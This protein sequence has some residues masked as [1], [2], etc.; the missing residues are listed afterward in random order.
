[1]AGGEGS[2][3][4]PLTCDCPKPMLRLMGRPLMEY[5]VQLLHRHGIHQIAATLGYLPDPILDYFAESGLHFRIEKTPM[6]TA[7]SVKQAAEFL[8]ER[9]IVLSGDG[10]TDIDLGAALRFHMEKRALATL[11]LKKHPQPQEYGM[12]VTDAYGRI[13]SFHEKP[14]RSDAYSSLINTGIYILERAVLDLIPPNRPYDFGHDLFPAM[15]A[16][17]LPI[18]G[19]TAEGYW[20]DVGDPAAYL[21]VHR[22]ALDGKIRLE[23]L[24]PSVRGAVLEPGCRID[25]P[26]FIA[27]YTRIASGAHIGAYSVIGEGCRVDKGADIKRSILFSGARIAPLAQLRGCIIG[28]NAEIG[29]AAQLFEES[30]VGSGS[31]IGQHATLPPGI[32]LWPEKSLAGGEK[33]E[34]N[35]VWGSRREQC[36]TAGALALESPAQ[37]ARAAQACAAQLLPREILIGRAPSAVAAAMWHAAAAGA[38]AQGTQTVDAGICTLPQLRHALEILHADAALLVQEDALLPLDGHG[39]PLPEKTQRAILKKLERQDFPAPFNRITRPMACAAPT[40]AAYAAC[41]AAEFKADPSRAPRILL[42]AHLPHQLALAEQILERTGLHARFANAFEDAQNEAGEIAVS[43][44]ESG[45]SA[46]ISDEGNPL[47]EAERQLACAWTALEMGER[48]LI[49]PNRATRAIEALAKEYNAR[50]LYLPGEDARWMGVMAETAPRQFQLQFDGLRFALAFLSCLTDRN[51]SLAQWRSRM[52]GVFRS[53]RYISLPLRQSSRLMHG[54]AERFPDAE[55]GGGMRLLRED[56][57][58][59]LY[60]DDSGA[61]LRIFSEAASM[62]A[63][64]EICDF[65]LKEIEA[66]L[67]KSGIENNSDL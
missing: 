63:A 8:N 29:E 31:R 24:A 6:G 43:L 15:A 46:C 33:P 41:A 4:R 3:L 34:E 58:A 12:V 50:C 52:P 54:L 62:E 27:P 47:S 17:G 28:T 53:Q 65:C 38:M 5:A 7:G 14:G 21:Q 1:M 36:F 25:E 10:I 13:R 23:G 9:F 49:L 30:I 37:A 20:C 51:L 18:Y 42:S 32:K 66:I 22:D 45:E 48:Q 39:V 55:P 44:S 61:Q 16:E 56:G 67:G 2:R 19:Y 64:G 60:P 11:I 59:F 26:V 40:D 57:W 35:I